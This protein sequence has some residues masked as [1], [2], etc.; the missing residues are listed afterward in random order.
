MRS[1]L[2]IQASQC[3]YAER[4]KW[5][6]VNGQTPV[7]RTMTQRGT[8]LNAATHNLT[9]HG[10]LDPHAQWSNSAIDCDFND[11]SLAACP[12]HRDRGLARARTNLHVQI[13]TACSLKVILRAFQWCDLVLL[14][15]M[16]NGMPALGLD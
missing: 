3:E 11:R 12:R 14:L 1:I 16:S 7:E 2:T 13:N 4:T 6:I 9:N 15:L 5:L 8:A 10:L